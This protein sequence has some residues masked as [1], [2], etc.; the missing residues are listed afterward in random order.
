MSE[1]PTKFPVDPLQQRM[2][3]ILKEHGVNGAPKERSPSKSPLADL[4]DPI[5]PI[6]PKT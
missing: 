4:I 5:D 1:N 3:E 6:E 2:N